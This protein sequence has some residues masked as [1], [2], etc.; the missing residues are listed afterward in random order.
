MAQ[1]PYASEREIQRASTRLLSLGL[2]LASESAAGGTRIARYQ[3][4]SQ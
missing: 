3:L 2:E 4:P 1:S